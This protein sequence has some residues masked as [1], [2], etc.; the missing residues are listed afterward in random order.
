MIS[1]HTHTHTHRWKFVSCGFLLAEWQ[2]LHVLSSTWPQWHSSHFLKANPESR[3]HWYS[4]VTTLLVHWQQ[5]E[6]LIS[7]HT[8]AMVKCQNIWTENNTIHRWRS[9]VV[10]STCTT[11]RG[12]ILGAFW[13]ARNF[14]IPS[15]LYSH[16]EHTPQSCP[17]CKKNNMVCILY[18]WLHSSHVTST[19]N[20]MTTMQK[21]LM[22]LYGSHWG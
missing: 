10:Q 4:F 20:H 11:D 12:Y 14:T 16:S 6:A 3:S 18:R 1:T 5:K 8:I 17:V 22:S 2:E 7:L 13:A 21:T 15:T 9:Q 19:G